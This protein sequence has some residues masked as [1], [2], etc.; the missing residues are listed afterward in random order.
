MYGPTG[1][2]Q[3]LY[4]CGT[5]NMIMNAGIYS[6]ANLFMGNWEWAEM[7]GIGVLLWGG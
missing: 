2:L 6:R 1:S 3:G 7:Y 4:E 5:S